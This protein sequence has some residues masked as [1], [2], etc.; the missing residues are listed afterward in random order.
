LHGAKI[1]PVPR[2]LRDFSEPISS[3]ELPAG[4]AIFK[5]GD[6]YLL[7]PSVVQPVPNESP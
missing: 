2:W 1:R 3:E 6:I 4:V 5:D 7:Q